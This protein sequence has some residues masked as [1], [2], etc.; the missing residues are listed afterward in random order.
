VQQFATCGHAPHISQPQQNI[1]A[2]AA[3]VAAHLTV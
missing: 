1:A 2:V 3:F